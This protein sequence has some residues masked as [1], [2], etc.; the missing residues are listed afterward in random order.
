MAVGIG[1][2]LPPVG[3]CFFIACSIG[4]T[5]LLPSMR[6]FLPYLVVLMLGLLV[7]T[8]VPEITLVLPRALSGR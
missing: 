7:I 4:R 1:V 8:F 5:E 6:A 2:F 3:V